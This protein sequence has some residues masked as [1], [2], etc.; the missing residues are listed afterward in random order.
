MNISKTGLSS[1]AFSA[2][3]IKECRVA[4]SPGI[5]FGKEWDTHIRVSLIENVERFR[6]GIVKLASFISKYEKIN[7]RV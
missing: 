4:T 2:Q 6:T 3:F 5:A 7:K 1:N